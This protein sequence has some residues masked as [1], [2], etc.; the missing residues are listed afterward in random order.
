MV[1]CADRW[2]P[3]GREARP[4]MG[5][6]LRRIIWEGGTIKRNSERS[7]ELLSRRKLEGH[8]GE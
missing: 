3:D 8:L 5:V 7:H 1:S 2:Q 6:K 4:V